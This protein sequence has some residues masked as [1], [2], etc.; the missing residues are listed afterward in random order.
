[1]VDRWSPEFPDWAAD[2]ELPT[3]VVLELVIDRDGALRSATVLRAVHPDLERMAMQ[4]VQR[5]RFTA[6]TRDGVP[7]DA[8]LNISV[9]FG[10]D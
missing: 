2:A 3:F 7:V 9:V 4:A 1:M 6:A 10:N 8:Y 5:W